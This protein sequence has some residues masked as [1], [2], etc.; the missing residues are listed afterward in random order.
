[1]ALTW[2]KRVVD[3]HTNWYAESQRHTYMVY[4]RNGLFVARHKVRNDDSAEEL[5][6][7][8]TDAHAL[9][10]VDDFHYQFESLKG[11]PAKGTRGTRKAK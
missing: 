6:L 11:I 2:E 1:M 10:A 4:P 5:G 7:Y 9:D 3:G 8:P